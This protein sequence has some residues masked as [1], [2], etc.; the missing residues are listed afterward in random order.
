MP[1]FTHD[2]CIYHTF[3]DL[4][5]EREN[6]R[7]KGTSQRGRSKHLEY[8]SSV[9][10]QHARNTNNT[11]DPLT[12]TAAQLHGIL[13]HAVHLQGGEHIALV[14]PEAVLRHN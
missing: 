9:G 11:I 14:V 10:V 12:G 1:H 8:K 13:S 2:P 7:I 3:R 5:W 6:L 4:H